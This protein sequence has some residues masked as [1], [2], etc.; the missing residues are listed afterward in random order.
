MIELPTTKYD[1]PKSLPFPHGIRW[2]DFGDSFILWALLPNDVNLTRDASLDD[3][4]QLMDDLLGTWASRFHGY[5]RGP[6]QMFCD[7]PGF[8]IGTH[9]VLLTASGGRDC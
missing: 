7:G 2:S 8:K 4:L 3:C 5:Y 9:H 1:D 6:G